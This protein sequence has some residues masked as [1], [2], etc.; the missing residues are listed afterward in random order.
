MIRFNN[1]YSETCHENI[2]KRLADISGGQFAG[3]G[4]DEICAEAADIIRKLTGK[5]EADVHFLVGGTQTNL[6]VIAS[7]L[8]PYQCA[9]CAV[10][11]HINVHETGAVEATGHKVI[12][13]ES[14]NGKITAGDV[15]EAHRLHWQDDSHEHIA[16]PKLVYI[17]Q[18]TETGTVYRRDELAELYAACRECGMYLFIDGARLGYGL[19]S[20]E[21]DMDIKFLADNCDVF[22]IGG[23]KGGAM[24]GE[25]VVI[26]NGSLKEDFRYMI[27]QRGGMLAKG[28]L[29]GAQFSELL[30]DGLY[31]RLAKKADEQAARIRDAFLEAGYPSYAQSPT[32]QQFFILPGEV[33]EKLSEKYVFSRQ[34]T[35]QDGRVV[36]RIC[37][38]WAT[39]DGDV[40]E[41]ITDIKNIK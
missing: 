20:P 26:L 38:S 34:E 31:F 35:L 32:N 27:K 6:I 13:I 16:Q 21:C 5:P 37:T 10:T 28:W 39:K 29:L 40:E 25:A 30:R 12:G 3:Y 18:P 17:S 22:Y 14:E 41:L 9:V 7:V 1:D 36:I 8:R 33:Y 23:T 19:E 2:L 24:F 15:R 11:G 4:E